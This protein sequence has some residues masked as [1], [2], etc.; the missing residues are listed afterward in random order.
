[1]K[2]LYNIEVDKDNVEIY[3][4]L[5]DR[6]MTLESFK[7]SSRSSDYKILSIIADSEDMLALRLCSDVT[8]VDDP[9]AAGGIQ[10]SIKLW[11]E[12]IRDRLNRIVS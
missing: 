6:Q 4:I 1:M 5:K 11:S 12:R 8:I 9:E 3:K 7:E 2:K 10:T